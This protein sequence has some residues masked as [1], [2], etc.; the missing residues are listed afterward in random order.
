VL[1]PTSVALI[2][3]SRREGTVGAAVLDNLAARGYSGALYIVHPHADE[4]AGRKTFH[5]IADVPGDVDLAVVA[6]PADAVVDVARECGEAG[7][8]ALVVL[9][10][11]FGEVGGDGVRRQQE[12]LE[13]CRAAG[14]RLVG[15]NCLGV[16]ATRAGLD[17]TF[18]PDAPP[19]GRIAFASQS[20][21]FGI[22][23]IAEAA[24][25]GLGL[26]SFASM[27]NKA[28]LS[29]NDFIRYWERTPIRTRSCSTS[30][31]SAI[32]AASAGSLA[33]SR[34][35]SRSSRS[36]AAAQRPVRAPRPRTREHCSPRP[37]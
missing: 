30:S 25:R 34:R 19:P 8:R 23:A 20:G 28:D 17:A 6:V 3:A 2:G 31:L 26:S 32:R 29:G 4:L 24:R 15:P 35:A 12:L 36:R 33:W 9:S 37:T 13:T 5:S 10:A 27:G 18:A 14:M 7:V 21:A 16:I 22:L 11:G 1:N